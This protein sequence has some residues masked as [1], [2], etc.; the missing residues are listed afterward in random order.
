MSTNRNKINSNIIEL[1][2]FIDRRNGSELIQIE[3]LEINTIIIDEDDSKLNQ[4][5]D[6]VL[7]PNFDY[8]FSFNSIEALANADQSQFNLIKDKIIE[9]LINGYK[10]KKEP[11]SFSAH[12]NIP[13]LIITTKNI[14]ET[15]SID[16]NIKN[17]V[18]NAFNQKKLISKI[19]LY[20]NH[21]DSFVKTKN[22]PN[23]F[24]QVFEHIKKNLCKEDFN[25]NYLSHK[26]G[27]SQRQLS[28]IIT[29]EKNMTPAKYI[30]E[31]RLE[32]AH[33]LLSTSKDL[34][35]KEIKYSIGINSSS[36]FSKKFKDRFGYKPSEFKN[37][38]IS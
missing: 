34:K 17:H 20:T 12:K 21:L 25:V 24:T 35:I 4:D 11:L 36:Y 27:Y 37:N 5:Y 9:P 19:K 23:T 30:L 16:S 2:S 8:F 13:F 7:N 26:T 15:K 18:I 10:F 3:D 31:L 32:K 29:A 38:L 33:E 28:R 6:K 14:N 1:I 22:K